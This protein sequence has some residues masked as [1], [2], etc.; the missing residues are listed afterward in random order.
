[1]SVC[2]IFDPV[3][4]KLSLI[5][6]AHLCMYTVY[7]GIWYVYIKL[8]VYT[9]QRSD[10]VISILVSHLVLIKIRKIFITFFNLSLGSGNL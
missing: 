6:T 5:A 3:I 8:F 10:F 9:L 4:L 2:Y 1:M 7:I